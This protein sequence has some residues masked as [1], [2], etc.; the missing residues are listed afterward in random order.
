MT[1]ND[2]RVPSKALSRRILPSRTALWLIAGGFL[3]SVLLLGLPRLEPSDGGHV[4]SA[5][6]LRDEDA[7]LSIEQVVGRD[8]APSDRY[9]AEG[10]TDAAIW[11]RLAIAR[12]PGPSGAVV[13]RIFPPVLDQISLYAADPSGSGGWQRI[14]LHYS[15]ES[16]LRGHQFDIPPEGTV[17][18]LRLA[19]VGSIT[20]G[21]DVLT[22]DEAVSFGLRNDIIQ[23]AYLAVMALLMIWSYRMFGLTRD[24]LFL[25]FGLVQSVWIVHNLLVFGY[26]G[27]LVQLWPG[28]QFPT[29]RF[30]ALVNAFAG[31][32]FHRTVIA[33]YRPPVILLRAI[34]VLLVIL[35]VAIA[36]FLAGERATALRLNGYCIFVM[37][38][39]LLLASL[40]ARRDAGPGLA[41][42][43]LAYLMLTLSLVLWVFTLMGFGNAQASDR[44]SV[45]LH[46]LSTGFLMFIF[47]RL[48][49]RDLLTAL[50]Q[51]QQA[52][53]AV[54]TLR[55]VERQHS[56]LRLRF[57]DMLAHETRNALAIINMSVGATA[58]GDR[59]RSRVRDTI[60]DLDSIIE[61]SIR[62][63][64]MQHEGTA[65][66][67]HPCDL[68]ALADETR[69]SSIRADRIRL[70]APPALPMRSDPVLIKVILV[71][72]I[73]NATKYSA[74]DASIDIH[75][76]ANDDKARITVENPACPAFGMPDPDRVFDKFYRSD[77]A[78]A[79]F[80]SGLGLS[81]A[82][83]LTTVLGGTIRYAPVGKSVRFILD[84]P[85]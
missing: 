39:L 54:E 47:L 19:S 64:K 77:L 14:D 8:F 69:Q 75:I 68:V 63:T 27:V 21:I 25:S 57:I 43:R 49:G 33:R 48:H 34:D 61:R 58:F 80:G 51:A 23:I 2:W 78:R 35:A 73:E 82:Q 40:T 56:E 71:N 53:V 50:R 26:L 45:L 15:A 52:L 55:S 1:S 84:L 41:T 18:Y 3:I 66:T 5:G 38:F 67:D 72:L 42:V 10:Y 7:T 24:R 12:P 70:H 44:Y 74:D 32:A 62:L 31:I 22:L 59:Q 76:D 30:F 28:W 17:L 6:I 60:A 85:C 46:G 16:M 81:I 20:A 83:H 13:L 36:I 4:T 79:Q 9:I 11:M 65:V 37:P 29:L